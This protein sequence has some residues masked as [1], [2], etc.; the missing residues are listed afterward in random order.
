VG[1]YVLFNG[2]HIILGD[3]GE[4]SAKGLGKVRAQSFG[5]SSYEVTSRRNEDRV[6]FSLVFGSLVV[7]ILVRILLTKGLLFQ[8][9]DSN[10]TNRIKF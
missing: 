8:D 1:A 6:I 5:Q 2:T 7:L 10:A 4:E 9:L 3:K